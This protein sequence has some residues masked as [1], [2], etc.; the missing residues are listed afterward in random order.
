[1]SATADTLVRS[2]CAVPLRS[3]GEYMGAMGPWLQSLL[4]RFPGAPAEDAAGGRPDRPLETRL[5]ALTAGAVRSSPYGDPSRMPTVEWEGLQYRVDPAAATLR[6][7]QNVRDVMGGRS[8]DAVL[9]FALEVEALPSASNPARVLERIRSLAPA[10]RLPQPEGQPPSRFGEPNLL[11]LLSKTSTL[12]EAETKSGNHAKAAR[13]QEEVEPATDRYLA[14][15]RAADWYLASVLSSVVYASDV[16]E[17]GSQAL[18]GGDPSALHD[19]GLDAIDPGINTAAPWRYPVEVRERGVEWHM[20]G[21]L[22]GLDVALGRFALR[23]VSKDEVPPAP[24]LTDIERQALTEPVLLVSPFD[25]SDAGRD[26]VVAALAR[27]RTILAGARA[28]VEALRKAAVGVGFDE[29]REQMLVWMF[30][31][32]PGR[33]AELWS[34]GEIVRLGAVGAKGTGAF[35]PFGSSMWSVRGQLACRFPWHQP[36]TTL[37]GRK[38][39]RLVPGLVPD[40]AIVVAESLAALKLPARL[41]VGVLSVATQDLLDTVRVNHDDD[42]MALVDGVRQVAGRSFEDY[43]ANL[44]Y[45]GPLIPLVQEPRHATRQ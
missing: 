4:L 37:A 7:L 41:S 18:L 31:H 39:V 1:M 2:L 5:L 11:E 34:L 3:D 12:V 27:G 30:E 28:S 9:Q 42:W 45:D 22:L 29:W 33:L 24:R 19:L 14:I 44:T 23:R 15:R 21:S 17:R 32:E 20:R 13:T 40:L 35:D 36:W 43:V 26:E 8:F 10:V 16:G 6:R 25:P 38:G